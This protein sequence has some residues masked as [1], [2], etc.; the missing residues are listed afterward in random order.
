M[1]L[2][3]AHLEKSFTVKKLG[4]PKDDFPF[5]PES[6]PIELIVKAKQI[7]QW[8]LDRYGLCA[9]LQQ[10]PAASDQPAQNVTLIPMGAARLRIAA[11]PTVGDGADAHQ[12]I[13]PA[14]KAGKPL[15]K[16][17]ASHCF[18]GDSVDALCDGIEPQNSNYQAIPRFTWWDHRGTAEWVQYDFAAARKVSSAQVY[19][20]DDTG[21]GECRV[22][23]SWQ[24]LYK[25]GDV[26]KP[27]EATSGFGVKKDRWNSV[28]LQAVEATALR[29]TVQLEPQFSGG[30]LEWKI[31]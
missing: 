10:S 2:D 4:W 31:K 12:W 7:P 24:L 1:A 29:I 11:F 17:S 23:A 21:A 15:Y 14:L 6:A 28:E 18:S 8:T 30:I 5:T 22:P 20:F 9:T 16:A 27:V 3:G 13:E 26:W 19:W 25:V